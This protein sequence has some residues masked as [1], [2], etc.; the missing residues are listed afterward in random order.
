MKNKTN[1][2]GFAFRMKAR[3]LFNATLLVTG[4]FSATISQATSTNV[5]LTT[6]VSHIANPWPGSSVSPFYVGTAQRYT[7]LLVTN[8]ANCNFY[9]ETGTYETYGWNA[10]GEGTALRITAN[11]NCKHFGAGTNTII[12]LVDSSRHYISDGIIF[13]CDY[14]TQSCDGFE[15]RD[16]LLDCNANNQP[17]FA[18]GQPKWVYVDLGASETINKVVLE[19]ATY[20]SEE[21]Q[22]D[23]SDDAENWGSVYST[24]G[25]VGGTST[26]NFL[27]TSARFVR[28]YAPKLSGTN[29]LYQIREFQ[30]FGPSAP[31]SN[32]ASGKMAQGSGSHHGYE[33]S[34]VTDSDLDT[35]WEPYSHGMVTALVISGSNITISN[36]TI[37]GFGTKRGKEAFPLFYLTTKNAPASTVFSNVF[38]SGVTFTSPATNNTDGMT[39]CLVGAYS[40]GINGQDGKHFLQNAIVTNCLILNTTSDFWYA[41]GFSV[42]VLVNSVVDGN[43]TAFYH[44]PNNTFGYDYGTDYLIAGNLFTNISFGIQYTISDA[45]NP[46]DIGHITAISNRIYISESVPYHGCAF[47]WFTFQGGEA[48]FASITLLNNIVSTNDS[49]AA[50]TNLFGFDFQ[51]TSM[52]ERATNVH[53]GF[54]SISLPHPSMAIRFDTNAVLFASI[55]QNRDLDSTLLTLRD[56]YGYNGDTNGTQQKCDFNLDTHTD[57]LWRNYTTGSNLVWYMNTT[58]LVSFEYIRH[59]LNLNYE[60]RGTAD[61]T[62]DCNNDLVWRLN[63]ATNNA[64]WFMESTNFVQ[65]VLTR[66]AG[67]A[68]DMAG[69]GDFNYDGKADIIWRNYTT[70]SNVVWL[71]DGTNF[72]EALNFPGTTNLTWHLVGV[73]D[74]NQDG[75]DDLLWRFYGNDGI[76][77]GNNAIWYMDGTN[78]L[79][80]VNIDAETNLDWEIQAVGDFNMDAKPDIVW[81]NMS[82]GANRIWLMDNTT[83]L[84]TVNLQT[85]SNLGWE[86]VGPK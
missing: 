16:M 60:I 4:L 72:I 10:G 28:F 20:F 57:L 84:E 1:A 39:V 41:N 65:S 55:Y 8:N 56:N 38:I 33:P 83:K 29:D 66:Q 25:G 81:R 9:Y 34:N 58:N 35:R 76:R 19:W 77:N 23:V 69:T 14:E 52:Q 74:F 85:V 7:D 62:G 3:K 43:Q 15:V 45:E 2:D 36:A 68:W 53:V 46:I 47:D 24:T 18:N 54:N 75:K 48:R 73:G 32:L 30:V 40:D 13:A 79:S 59:Q 51:R 64:F 21:Y 31:T 37:I 61:F 27:D 78:L 6:N 86:I 42:P 50:G 71:M 11:P 12:K 26:I 49:G 70:G 80:N 17:K 63:G 44:E 5:Y 22:I 82:T 67:V